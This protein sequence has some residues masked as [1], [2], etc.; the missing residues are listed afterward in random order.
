[1]SDRIV[2]LGHSAITC[3]GN[4]IESTWAGMIAGGSG[5]RRQPSLGQG[6]HL[7][8]RSGSTGVEL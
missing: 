3:L 4:D 5:L 7:E 1:M 2:F 6:T 8:W